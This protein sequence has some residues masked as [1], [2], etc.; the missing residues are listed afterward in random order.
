M[1]E[2]VTSLNLSYGFDGR[3]HCQILARQV[4]LHHRA[5]A[6]LGDL[7]SAVREALLNPVDFPDAGRALV[8]GDRVVV[9]IDVDTPGADAIFAELWNVMKQSGVQPGD[10]T[11]LQPA[12]WKSTTAVDPRRLLEPADRDEIE[13]HRHDPTEE[14]GCAYLAS[15]ASGER[16]YLSRRLTDADVVVTIGPSEFDPV[17]GVRSTSSSLYPGLSDLEALKKFRGQGHEELGP[18][19]ARPIRQIVDEI[20]WLLGLQLSFSVIPASGMGAHAV[21][22]GQTDSV[23][24]QSRAEL[25]SKWFVKTD[26][27]AELVLVTVTADAAGHSWDQVAAA[28]DAGRRLVERHGRIVVLSQLELPPGPGLEILKEVREPRDALKPIQRAQTPD[29]LAAT[30]IALAADW[31]NVSLLSRLDPGLVSDLFLVPLES[32]RELQRLLEM[33]H[34]TA[35]IESAQHAFVIS[36]V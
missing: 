29:L 13:L 23:L 26:E 9:V 32:E 27:R 10:V 3:F 36:G 2:D 31:A 16:V 14:G 8:A 19:E 1:S 28:I 18:M 4:L 6:P 15:T 24:R 12:V 22:A 34:L 21:I 20:G 5:P 7:R 30:R 25:E 35:I 33:E 11:L 17:L